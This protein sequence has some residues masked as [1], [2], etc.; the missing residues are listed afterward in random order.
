MLLQ[1]LSSRDHD[2]AK[3]SI[4]QGI[5]ESMLRDLFDEG[6]ATSQNDA[7]ESYNVADAGTLVAVQS[8]EWRS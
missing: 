4:H 7:S 2:G 6:S 1:S 3:T 5:Q 8:R